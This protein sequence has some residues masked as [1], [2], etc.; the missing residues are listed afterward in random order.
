[1][2]SRRARTIPAK[3]FKL[4]SLFLWY[5]PHVAGAVSEDLLSLLAQSKKGLRG[6]DTIRCRYQVGRLVV[7]DR[8]QRSL[9]DWERALEGRVSRAYLY[10][11]TVAYRCGTAFPFVLESTRLKVSHL[12]AVEDLPAAS[13][14]SLLRQAE[15]SGWSVRRLRDE[16]RRCVQTSRAARAMTVVQ[17]ALGE[18]CESLS[19][20]ER[21]RTL[22]FEV[23][24]T[25]LA[26][27]ETRLARA[28]ALSRALVESTAASQLAE[29]PPSNSAGP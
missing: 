17:Q 15:A 11:C 13:Q 3:S 20:L 10:R 27:V 26:E 18:L 4:G 25:R 21:Q 19:S 23:G 1:M 22:A 6:R 14:E 24:C 9:R 12:D 29:A 16:A 8:S 7:A 28:L 5:A 2:W